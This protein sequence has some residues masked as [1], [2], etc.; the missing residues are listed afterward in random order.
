[1]KAKEIILLI[2]IVGAGIFFYHAHTGKIDID[3]GCDWDG[4]F[5][6]HL[7]EF[8]YEEF[9]EIDPPLP[10]QLEID[11]AHGDIEIQGGQE[12][13]IAISFQKIIRR[14][15][16]EKAKE[17]AD[18]LK[19]IVEKNEQQ[20]TISTNRNDFSRKNFETNFRISVPKGTTIKV[21]NSYGLVKTSQ[22]GAT[23]IYNRHGKITASD[24][25]GEIVI[26]NSYKD[27]EVENVQSDCRVESKHGNVFISNV[28]GNTNIGHRYGKIH[29]ENLSQNVKIEGSHTEVFGQNLTGNVE[30]LTSYENVALFDV[31]PAK[32]TGSHA[33]VEIDGVQGSLEIKHRYGEVKLNNIQ[34]NL[35]VEGKN[36]GVLGRTIVGEK[37]YISS[38][39]RPIDLAEFAGKTE[40]FLSHGDIKLEPSPLTYP[41]EVKGQYT[42]IRLYW[43]A[44]EKYPFEARVERGDIKWNL[45]A[46]LSLV[47][48]NRVTTVKAFAQET[49]KPSIFLSTSYGTIR[50][51]E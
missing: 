31:G 33:R 36:V 46:E 11:N 30:V 41:I 3:W 35:S 45:P 19:M 21:K 40:L 32:I 25:D 47:E 27:V 18:A 5:F 42:N 39:Y 12:E 29:L 20:L 22:V 44:G 34:G 10:S 1:M 23:D 15:N 14:K 28:Q 8:T 48:E 38:S 51:E 49:E 37:I 50:V 16:E 2:L 17:V 24:I 6:I 4:F 13:K 9:E 26:Q 7:E 43:P